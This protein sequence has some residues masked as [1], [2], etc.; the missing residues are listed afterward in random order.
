MN[1]I[2]FKL[3][4][5]LTLTLIFFACKKNEESISGE[6]VKKLVVSL[7]DLKISNTDNKK[8]AA[9]GIKN[10][11]SSYK[12]TI[13]NEWGMVVSSQNQTTTQKNIANST[14]S[15]TPL[16]PKV[17]PF[18][19]SGGLNTEASMEG[20]LPKGIA[21]RVHIFNAATNELIAQKIYRNGSTVLGAAYANLPL[22]E[23]DPFDLPD[24]IPKIKL[25]AFTI[26]DQSKPLNQQLIPTN[27]NLSIYNGSTL[28]HNNA[29]NTAGYDDLIFRGIEGGK[30]F[31]YHSEEI[32]VNTGPSVLYKPL[33]LKLLNSY[34]ALDV[35]LNENDVSNYE[36]MVD[37]IEAYIHPGASR[38]D[39]TPASAAANGS[40]TFSN[41]I[42]D[43]NAIRS[44]ALSLNNVPYSQ[45]LGD[46]VQRSLKYEGTK[47]NVQKITGNRNSRFIIRQSYHSTKYTN[48]VGEPSEA[49]VT[50][51]DFN[52]YANSQTYLKYYRPAF[53]NS[54]SENI[55]DPY[56]DLNKISHILELRNVRVRN[57]TTSKF[58]VPITVLAL[59]AGDGNNN[60]GYRH[61]IEL[62]YG[63][64][65]D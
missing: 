11:N 51:T 53:L 57:K 65:T 12:I 35:F 21:F 14:P 40:V 24:D 16:S 31:F 44:S 30:D 19:Y 46:H 27:E 62:N 7:S 41:A 49:A 22:P 20:V 54:P 10:S 32:I 59:V 47:L 15:T 43:Q 63:I 23:N 1:K 55:N 25:V 45:F 8:V 3:I 5:L 50:I 29:L 61:N 60:F 39:I 56:N 34:L 17:F 48:Y 37:E 52:N 6:K 64:I 13:D 18:L 33:T 36:L 9:N 2:D 28:L 58:S 42:Y 26:Y 38:Y 4:A